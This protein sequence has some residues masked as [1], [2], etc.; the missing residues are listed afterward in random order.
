MKANPLAHLPAAKGLLALPPEVRGALRQLLLDLRIDA[1]ARA[2]HSWKK[3]K[4]PMAVYWKAV[5]VYAGWI[6]RLLR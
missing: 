6:A 3:N 2:Q 4:G 1:A 5:S